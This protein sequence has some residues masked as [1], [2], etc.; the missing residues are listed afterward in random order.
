MAKICITGIAGLLGSNLAKTLIERGHTI[1]GIDNLI[2]GY[3]DNI[4]DCQWHRTDILNLDTI[5]AFIYGC[6]IIINLSPTL[7]GIL[8]QCCWRIA[9]SLILSLTAK[10]TI[11]HSIYNSRAIKTR[12]FSG[13]FGFTNRTF[14][15]V[16]LLFFFCH[17]LSVR[18]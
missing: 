7:I 11:L 15:N 6:E 4:P 2:G 8:P 16:F 9:T 3:Q 14:N 17:K 1:I 10:L 12:K 13:L 5:T 18:Y